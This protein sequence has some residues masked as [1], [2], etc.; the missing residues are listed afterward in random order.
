MANIS[1]KLFNQQVMATFNKL[2]D[3]ISALQRETST[4]KK[5]LLAS[6]DPIAVSEL[7][8][9]K[10]LLSKFDRYLENSQVASSRLGLADAA[11]ISIAPILTRFGELNIQAMNDTLNY[12]DRLSILAE[13]KEL[14]SF[15]VDIANSRDNNSVAIF[16][17]TLGTEDPFVLSSSNELKYRGDMGQMKL[18]ISENKI[19]DSAVSGFET[20]MSVQTPEGKKSI[21]SI[22][23]DF[24]KALVSSEMG[25]PKID[26]SENPT[27]L[28]FELPE[29]ITSLSFNINVDGVEHSVT[30]RVVNGHLEKLGTQL[31]ERDLP[32][33]FTI[34]DDNQMFIVGDQ[35]H[36]ISLT[37]LNYV[38][39]GNV[40]SFEPK[41]NILNNGKEWL[42]LDKDFSKTLSNIN[43]SI[44]HISLQQAM[45]G[46]KIKAAD[47][48]I[49][50]I[51]NLRSTVVEDISK[52]EDADLAEVVTELKQLLL[53][54][55]AAQQVYAKLNQQTL[56]DFI[57]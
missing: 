15:L 43:A 23:D 11:L 29:T 12:Q 17:G 9:G 52:L 44:D 57:R 2:D 30:A 38:S 27:R 8:A 49:D 54:K 33:R 19:I 13:V 28:H 25:Q 3:K 41:I 36:E 35:S 31:S 26:I 10:E 32:I 39:S 56:F 21:F 40:N 18:A 4:G 6:D 50:I 5:I 24:S 53:N 42:S 46:A 51:Q 14:K 55:D 7:N 47:T 37:N 1:S 22:I 20:F 45:L 34:N 16:G 48:Q